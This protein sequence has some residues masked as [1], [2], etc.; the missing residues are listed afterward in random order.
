M[1][2]AAHSRP[3]GSVPSVPTASWWTR[4]WSRFWALPLAIVLAA[5]LTGALLPLV[6]ARL[7]HYVPYVFQGGP[8]GARSMLGTIASA[9]IS[10]TGLVFSITMVVLQ[11]A[12]SQFTPRV[13][14]GF[15]DSRITQSTLGVFTASFIFALTV[16][17][18]VRGDTQERGEFVPQLSVSVAFLLVLAS[19]GYLL[20]F[21]HHITVSIQVSQVISG[22][23]DRTMALIE[24]IYPDFAAGGYPLGP[25]WSPTPDAASVCIDALGH[26]HVVHFDYDVLLACAR[27]LDAVVVTEVSVGGF[28]PGDMPVVR[29]WGTDS[30]PER[31]AAR[32]RR[33]IGLSSERTMRQDVVFGFRQLVDI[34]ERALSPG[35][36]D[37]TT[38]V[39]VID[40]LHRMLR[41]LVGRATPSPYIADGDGVVRVV[42]RPASVEYLLTLAVEE[43]AHYG[44]TSLQVPRRLF[45]MVDDLVDVSDERYAGALSRVRTLIIPP[46][47]H[48]QAD[49]ADASS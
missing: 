35:I 40:E 10:V 11:L 5:L 4:L 7:A 30:L 18:S 37:P 41:I 49:G 47:Q 43:I 2:D 45:A 42:H 16:L 38:A 14:G 46:E 24:E 36:N 13:L 32:L 20:A 12:S 31:T 44:E 19:V 29:V 26:G 22:I 15:L 34:A 33:A 28:V 3:R 21:I 6:D 27:E 9:M 39:Q 48:R 17:R 23:G 8:D 25:T 1:S